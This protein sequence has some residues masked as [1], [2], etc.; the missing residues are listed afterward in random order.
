[1][2]NRFKS[3]PSRTLI[4]EFKRLLDSERFT[5]A[6][7]VEYVREIQRRQL[8]LELGY[9]VSASGTCFEK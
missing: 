9:T 2:K 3:V 5:V 6:E 7:I 8:Y 1:M 4:E